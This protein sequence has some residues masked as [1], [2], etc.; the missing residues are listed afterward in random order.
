[1]GFLD[2]A[3]FG[4][5]ASGDDDAAVLGERLAD[6]VERFLDGGVDEAAGIDDDEVGAGVVCCG[7]IALGAQLR[8]DALGVDQRFGTTEGNEPYFRVTAFFQG[9]SWSA[10]EGSRGTAG[11]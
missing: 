3:F 10:A 4:A 8:E 2:H 1:M 9:R 7:D 11:R 6:G 5:E